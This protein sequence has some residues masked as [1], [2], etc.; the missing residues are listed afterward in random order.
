MNTS[1][2][3]FLT[4]LISKNEES[5]VRTASE[6]FGISRQAVNRHLKAL[7]NE[8]LVVAQGNTRN[9]KYSLSIILHKE[10]TF[11]ITPA[12]EEDTVWRQYMA[13]LLKVVSG[14]VLEICQYGF[15]EMLNNAIDHSEGTK[16]TASIELTAA[17][18][19]L[20]I[21]DDGVGIFNK[22]KR[23][24]H[25]DDESHAI[26]ELSK[27]KLTTDPSR[28]SGEGIFFTSRGF[29]HFLI[30]AGHLHFMHSFGERDWL[31]EHGRKFD[32]TYVEMQIAV[33][34]ERTIKEIFDKFASSDDYGFDKTIVP[35]SL[36]RFGDENLVSRSQAKRLLTRFDRFKEVILDFNKVSSIGQAFADEIFRVFQSQHPEVSLK[37]MRASADVE[38]MIRRAKTHNN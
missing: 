25:L 10:Y 27:G 6:K 20:S 22:I 29:D 33:N 23:E 12:L 1:I 2:R 35:V 9:R 24:L 36:A 34:A 26:L 3:D 19:K 37:W 5:I 32:G 8:G 31:I 7:I 38:K 15:T 28:H 4:G 17:G 14:N 13:P 18:I 16:V 30:L 11:K 21:Q